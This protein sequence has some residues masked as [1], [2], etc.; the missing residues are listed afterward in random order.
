[1]APLLDQVGQMFSG[2]KDIVFLAANADDDQS[3]VAAY[4]AKHKVQGTLVYA[5][6]LDDALKV[7]SLPTVIVLDRGG[8]VV[9]RG[10]GF[11]PDGFAE[12]LA[13]AILS[14]VSAPRTPQP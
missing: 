10:E 6:G 13:Q 3:R 11:T 4:L 14:A 9:Y 2:S 7:E 8:K 12:G 1:M 5:D